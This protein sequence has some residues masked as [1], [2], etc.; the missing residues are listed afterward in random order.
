VLLH[1]SSDSE[2]LTIV[3]RRIVRLGALYVVA[4]VVTRLA[5]S[6]GAWRTCGCSSDCWCKKP[7]LSVFRWV[8][9]VARHRSVDPAK[10]QA[11]GHA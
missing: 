5:E 7:G 8:T 3:R 10:K 9:P 6:T 1:S 4:A 11:S 2:K